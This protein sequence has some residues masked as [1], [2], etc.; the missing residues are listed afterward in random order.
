MQLQDE[1]DAHAQQVYAQ[2]QREREQK[3][4]AEANQR[5]KKDFKAREKKEKCIIM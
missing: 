4:M 1:E 2:R 3:R 5:I